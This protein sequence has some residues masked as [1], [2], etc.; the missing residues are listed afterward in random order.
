MTA[1]FPVVPAAVI[2]FPLA[3]VN[4][5]AER[6]LHIMEVSGGSLQ[7]GKPL[8]LLV[9]V[10]ASFDAVLLSQIAF[11]AVYA[12]TPPNVFVSEESVLVVEL[13]VIVTFE[14]SAALMEPAPVPSAKV[15]VSR[16]LVTADVTVEAAVAVDVVLKI[17]LTP[18]DAGMFHLLC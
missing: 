18:A 8:M 10:I 11:M 12:K 3:M 16:W 1:I 2:V 15:Y 17:T 13:L 14:S 7:A 6:E 4:P 5:P 9:I